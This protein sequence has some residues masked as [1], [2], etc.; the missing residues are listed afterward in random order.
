M[1]KTSPLCFF[2]T[3]LSFFGTASAFAPPHVKVTAKTVTKESPTQVNWGYTTYGDRT[4][5][6]GSYT[7]GSSFL[8]GNMFNDPY[9]FERRYDR[10]NKDDIKR[11]GYYDDITY[12]GASSYMKRQT[13]YGFYNDYYGG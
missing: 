13:P 4:S 9:A 12:H 5:W 11:W 10:N 8:Q 1:M 6:D 3:L 7:L 2:L